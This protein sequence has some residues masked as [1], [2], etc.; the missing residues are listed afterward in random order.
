MEEKVKM[1]QDSVRK[2]SSVWHQD[3]DSGEFYIAC[4]YAVELC[5]IIIYGYIYLP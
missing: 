3:T 1:H 4:G 5:Y 2:I